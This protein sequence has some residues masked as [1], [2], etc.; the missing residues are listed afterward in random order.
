MTSRIAS[1]RLVFN[2][3]NLPSFQLSVVKFV[4]RALHVVVRSEVDHSLVATV[5]MGICEGDFPSVPQVVFEV[6]PAHTR[7]QVLDDDTIIGT[8]WG[9]ELR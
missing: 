3:S 8:H 1:A 4:Q 2:Q 5:G 7:R 9:C 6:L